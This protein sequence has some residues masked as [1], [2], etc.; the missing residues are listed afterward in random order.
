M[1]TIVGAIVMCGML[2]QPALRAQSHLKIT[3]T[4]GV[5]YDDVSIDSVGADHLLTH[6]DGTTLIIPLDSVKNASPRHGPNL[7]A[8]SIGLIAGVAVGFM[9]GS[10][11]GRA[12][13]EPDEP[14]VH[15]TGSGAE[16]VG[17]KPADNS[18]ILM[19]IL[20][21]ACGAAGGFLGIISSS[22]PDTTF[23]LAGR[24]P[25]EKRDILVRF[26]PATPAVRR[27]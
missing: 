21:I 18:S 5:C 4:N 25:T 12:N 13:E 6:V 26:A 27:R 16:V 1:K 22:P 14:I 20:P 15:Y 19:I 7:R 23:D 2:I 11:I 8:G 3:L 17:S 9:A 24:N 10:I